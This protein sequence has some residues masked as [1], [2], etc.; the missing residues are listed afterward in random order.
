MSRRLRRR[1]VMMRHCAG[2]PAL[3][4]VEIHVVRLESYVMADRTKRRREVNPRGFGGRVGKQKLQLELSL[5]TA[6]DN[7]TQLSLI[8]ERLDNCISRAAP[9]LTARRSLQNMAAPVSAYKDRQFLAVIGD[10]VSDSL[11]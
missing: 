11:H 8:P 10:E 7:A 2:N 4:I 1:H 3:R 5:G 6:G 9:P